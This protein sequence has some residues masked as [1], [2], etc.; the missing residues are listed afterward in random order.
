MAPCQEGSHE[1]GEV[2]WPNRKQGGASPL[3]LDSLL[4]RS[5]QGPRR[6]TWELLDPFQWQCSWWPSVRLH[7]LRFPTTSQRHHI[8][9]QASYT[10]WEPVRNNH[11]QT[12]AARSE[13]RR[14]S[15]PLLAPAWGREGCSLWA[16]GPFLSCLQMP[17]PIL[18]C[19]NR[20]VFVSPQA[21]QSHFWW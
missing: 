12:T 13:E 18:H 3:F 6:T 19:L 11:I 20:E 17:F 10:R 1:K 8:W 9:D 5:N 7:L 21:Q 15:W 4:L 14:F 2:T 16:P